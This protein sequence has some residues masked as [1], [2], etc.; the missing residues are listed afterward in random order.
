MQKG[1]GGLS[2][3][4]AV[5]R[6]EPP[7]PQGLPV[8]PIPWNEGVILKHSHL[9]FKQELFMHRA[10]SDFPRRLFLFPR[11]VGKGQA[12]EALLKPYPFHHP[13]PFTSPG[14][15]TI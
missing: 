6:A 15:Q 11:N 2:R 9:L 5:W 3:G 12:D 8:S 10:V 7:R 14:M 1:E 4:Q 13:S